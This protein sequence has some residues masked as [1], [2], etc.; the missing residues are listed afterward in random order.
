[1]RD[2]SGVITQ[3][4]EPEASTSVGTAPCVGSI[5]GTSALS[6]NN[7]GYIG[8]HY[9]DTSYNEHGFIRAPSGTFI[10]VNVPGAY[11]TAGVEIN[12]ANVAVGHWVTDTSC[13]DEGFIATITP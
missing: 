6:I 7:K 13:D 5:G 12:N 8:G 9:W 10:T 3:I 11:Q 4:D 1:M 2:S